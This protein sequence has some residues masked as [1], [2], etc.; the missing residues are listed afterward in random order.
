VDAARLRNTILH[1]QGYG[2]RSEWEKQWEVARWIEEELSQSGIAA[3]IETYEWNGKSWP[4]VIARFEG[5]NAQAAPVLLLAHFDSITRADDGVAPGADDNGSGVAVLLEAARLIRENQLLRP[6]W[7][8]FFSNE[9]RGTRGSRAFV[10][11][12]LEN[13]LKVHSAV[14]V[15]TV[16]Y[17]PKSLF[18]DLDAFVVNPGFKYKLK[19]VYRL[20]YN[21][22]I[23]IFKSGVEVKVVGPEN[24]HLL[25]DRTSTAL[26]GLG[27]LKVERLYDAGCV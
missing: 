4:N 3:A 12:I 6:V 8:C 7:F 25:V 1:L 5:S 16:G 22:A 27:G 23:A 13:G 10:Q 26:E 9:E 15:D 18:S 17:R 24:H 19:A 20:A 2:N 21:A 14:N 11:K